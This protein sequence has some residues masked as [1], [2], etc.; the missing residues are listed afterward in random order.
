MMEIV[1]VTKNRRVGIDEDISGLSDFDYFALLPNY[2]SSIGL[3]SKNSLNILPMNRK[4]EVKKNILD[5]VDITKKTFFLSQKKIF[6]IYKS[7]GI[8]PV[9]YEVPGYN[10][11]IKLKGGD[12]RGLESLQSFFFRDNNFNDND[13]NA[14][15]MNTDYL[16]CSY[17]EG[18]ASFIYTAE[19]LLPKIIDDFNRLCIEK[20]GLKITVEELG[21]PRT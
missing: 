6:F 19:T 3:I 15:E 7:K 20:S 1:L 11:I 18:E 14:L 4:N 16:I 9:L 5:R 2:Y 10:C 21:S 17:Y 12:Y 8:R 13:F